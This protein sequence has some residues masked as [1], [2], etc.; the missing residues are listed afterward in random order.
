MNNKKPII[1]AI[2]DFKTELTQ[3]INELLQ[4]HQLPM[5]LI[6]PIFTN[7]AKEVSTQAQIELLNT[8]KQ[9]EEGE[10]ENEA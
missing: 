7:M 5:Y 3:S 1:L 4:K 10:K 6:E 2:E 9:Y 8:R